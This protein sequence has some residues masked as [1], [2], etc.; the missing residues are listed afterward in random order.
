MAEVLART[1]ILQ[2]ELKGIKDMPEGRL[3]IKKILSFVESV[4]FKREKLV[5]DI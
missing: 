2:Q 4:L 1:E 3:K 5:V